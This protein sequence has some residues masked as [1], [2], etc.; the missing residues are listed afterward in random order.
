MFVKPP[1]DE[2]SRAFLQRGDLEW[3][4][5]ATGQNPGYPPVNIP[6]PTKID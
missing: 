2:D 5:M 1:D 4:E 3:P 6:I